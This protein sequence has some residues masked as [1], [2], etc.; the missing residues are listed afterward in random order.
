MQPPCYWIYQDG[1][2]LDGAQLVAGH[3]LQSLLLSSYD[4]S[5]LSSFGKTTLKE[6]TYSFR[7]TKVS[8][9]AAEAPQVSPDLKVP[10]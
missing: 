4:E 6:R 7:E 5:C 9:V 10:R 2:K 1:S 3:R 8:G